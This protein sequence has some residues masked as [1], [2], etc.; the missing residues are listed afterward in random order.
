MI[1]GSPASAVSGSSRR[2]PVDRPI[3]QGFGDMHAGYC[4]RTVGVGDGACDARNPV[5]RA[6]ADRAPRH[7][8]VQQLHRTAVEPANGAN[9]GRGD[10]G[11]AR[12]L[13][14][15][16]KKGCLYSN[17]SPLPFFT[18]RGRACFS[19]FLRVSGLFY[20]FWTHLSR[21]LVISLRLSPGSAS[22]PN[23]KRPSRR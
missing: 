9:V 11:V 7:R 10:L 22:E 20:H 18:L 2:R 6:R 16:R 5:E 8:P 17:A 19:R 15:L 21:N 3:Q 14:R 23:C 1:R 12:D 13:N 4:G